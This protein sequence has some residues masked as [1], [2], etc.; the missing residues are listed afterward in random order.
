MIEEINQERDII[1][2]TEFRPDLF[3]QGWS[4]DLFTSWLRIDKY[5]IE[6][7]Q[8]DETLLQN[9]YEI[10][11][12]FNLDHLSNIVLNELINLKNENSSNNSSTF[13]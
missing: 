4:D 2:N 5:C 11:D 9:M 8:P 6:Q 1:M 7:S 13:K 12:R 3:F 10:L